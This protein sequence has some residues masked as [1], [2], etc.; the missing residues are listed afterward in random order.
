MV[1]KARQFKRSHSGCS[2]R[3]RSKPTTN[4][5]ATAQ[6]LA[7]TRTKKVVTEG[8]S[9][10]ASPD[11][12]PKAATTARGATPNP[13]GA[14]DQGPKP[15]TTI[16]AAV[17][18]GGDVFEKKDDKKNDE[19]KEPA[20]DGVPDM[21]AELMASAV[22][23]RQREPSIK[24][25]IGEGFYVTQSVAD[26]DDTLNEY[27]DPEEEKSNDQQA[28][29][30][31]KETG[32]QQKKRNKTSVGCE[33]PHPSLGRTSLHRASSMATGVHGSLLGRVTVANAVAS[34]VPN[35]PKLTGVKDKRNINDKTVQAAMCTKLFN[36]LK[37]R[38]ATFVYSD[39]T[40]RK[41]SG[42]ADFK[43]MFEFLFKQLDDKFSFSLKTLDEEVP[44]LMTAFGYPFALKKSSLQTAAAHSW[45]QVLAAL[46]W[47][48]DLVEKTGESEG[49]IIDDKEHLAFS[50]YISAYKQSLEDDK[51]STSQQ[52]KDPNRFAQLLQTYKVTLFDIEK[53]EEDMIRCKEGR[54]DNERAI[55]E[56]RAEAEK[57]KEEMQEI[58]EIIN[59][60]RNDVEKL[61]DYLEHLLVM[62]PRLEEN[63]TG[64]ESAIEQNNEALEK[65]E[66]E[67]QEKES[68]IGEQSMCG[69]EYRSMI[70][71]LKTLKDQKKHA[72]AQLRIE[73][74]DFYEKEPL[75]MKQANELRNDYSKL[76][77][78]LRRLSDFLETSEKVDW[79]RYEYDFSNEEDMNRSS[80][81]LQSL[82]DTLRTQ[83]KEV[84]V[85]CVE[86]ASELGRLTDVQKQI[87]REREDHNAKV[88]LENNISTERTERDNEDVAR[89]M[90]AQE[91]KL[92]MVKSKHETAKNELQ[93]LNE[94]A[95]DA[96]TKLIDVEKRYNDEKAKLDK[97]F[98]DI[99]AAT[100]E[101]AEK[102]YKRFNTL[103][104]QRTDI[105]N[106]GEGFLAA[107]K[108]ELEKLQQTNAEK[109]QEKEADK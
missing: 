57:D 15:P 58:E 100:F 45:P 82:V 73:E 14:A 3:K 35:F 78:A 96:K 103:M 39:A 30:S 50:Y 24:K 107:N 7:P 93:Q 20:K 74:K 11:K 46:D 25:K 34:R 41:P 52:E 18:V 16:G 102:L 22:I 12:A 13:N 63:I 68:K 5:D 95:D 8:T 75:V 76:L 66:A 29:D 38:E 6:S 49:G 92:K 91:K 48:V 44:K 94:R 51:K 31:P 77:I 70:A 88:K 60:K 104:K 87:L 19:P 21:A 81:E 27:P 108:S 55:D 109:E 10:D 43:N 33:T 79:K 99:M 26:E 61:N 98:S 85:V 4:I 89:Q 42:K 9:T 59:A 47:L 2:T 65:L 71:R 80:E 101:S 36:F 97:M 105:I 40:I 86:K 23:R 37:S 83:L 90:K 32:K 106:L 28:D 1:Q 62:I 69:D 17:G 84:I 64:A 72:L 67:N 56:L 54:R 53:I